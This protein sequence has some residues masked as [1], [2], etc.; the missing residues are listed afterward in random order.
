VFDFADRT[1]LTLSELEQIEPRIMVGSVAA[2]RR[3]KVN[4]NQAPREVLI[5]LEGL[6]SADADAL[7]ARR[8]TVSQSD[9]GSIAWVYDV[10]KERAIGLG[11]QIT[12][13]GGQYSADIVAVAGDGRAFKRVRIVVDASNPDAAPRILYRRDQTDLGWPLDP[14]ILESLRHSETIREG[15]A[16]PSRREA[17]DRT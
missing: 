3:G 2:N 4:V 1:Q 5:A 10:L 7:L 12:G 11:N 15:S 6:S 17:M 8:I 14:S 16:R 9:P 13:R